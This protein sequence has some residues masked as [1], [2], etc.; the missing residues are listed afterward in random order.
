MPSD[1]SRHPDPAAA[2]DRLAPTYATQEDD[3]YCADLEFPAMQDLLPDVAGLRVLDAG[4]GR[5]RYAEWLL[6]AGAEVVAVDASERMVERARARVG[7][8]AEVHRADLE[9]PLDF[10]DDGEFDG[11]VSGLALHYVEDLRPVF[12]EFA[13]LLAPGGFLAFS[14]HH[15]LDDYLVFEDA[16]YFDTERAT[17]TWPAGDGEV[18]VPFYRRPFADVV[19]PLVEARFGLDAVVEP[20]PRPSFE[21]KKPASYEKRLE[22]PT[23]LCVRASLTA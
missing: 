4:C 3:P 11:V 22:R 8:R 20:T 6:S 14:T 18:A 12:A 16:T 17:M 23:F 15:P 1:E 13:R 21:A 9:R 7:D 10:A 19:N 5:G 2:Y